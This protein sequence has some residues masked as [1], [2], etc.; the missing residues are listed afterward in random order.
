MMKVQKMTEE[1]V[2][3]DVLFGDL[4]KKLITLNETFKNKIKECSNL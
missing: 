2:E 4:N 1:R 3:N